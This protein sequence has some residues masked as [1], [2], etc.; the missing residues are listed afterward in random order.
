MIDKQF[1]ISHSTSKAL[2]DR[3]GE[4]R[5]RMSFCLSVSNIDWALVMFNQQ[6]EINWR[7]KRTSSVETLT[8]MMLM[9][10]I[11]GMDGV[12]YRR[13]AVNCENVIW[14]ELSHLS[15]CCSFALF[16]N[17]LA[18]LD[19]EEKLNLIGRKSLCFVCLTC[20]FSLSFSFSLKR[21]SLTNVNVCSSL[22]Q[23]IKYCH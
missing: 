19:E 22:A 1:P 13:L 21:S 20:T 5:K 4:K 6:N 7:K 15:F 3:S 16:H 18:L 2:S 9:V 12:W 8:M 11:K 17:W 14:E 10:L 23:E